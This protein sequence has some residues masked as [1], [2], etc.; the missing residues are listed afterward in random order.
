MIDIEKKFYQYG[1]TTI[2]EAF[3]SLRNALSIAIKQTFGDEYYVEDFSDSE[4]IFSIYDNA[5]GTTYEKVEY[6]MKDD[7]AVILGQPVDVQKKVVYEEKNLN[8]SQYLKIFE[9]DAAISKVLVEKKK[10]KFEKLEKKLS[11]KK[12]V[13]DPAGLAASI[14]RGKGGK[15]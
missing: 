11:R 1:K 14:C 4:V 8:V 6:K 5:N 3:V 10:S 12:G 15:L 13:Y 9:A 2:A 7:E